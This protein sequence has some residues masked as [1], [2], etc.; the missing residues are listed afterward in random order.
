[1]TESEPSHSPTLPASMHDTVLPD[2]EGTQPSAVRRGPT[3]IG[4][5]YALTEQ[6]GSG[7]MGVVWEAED[8]ELGRKVAVKIL[9]PSTA[10]ADAA[11][12]LR[13]EA[14]LLAEVQHP[15][16]VAVYD[17]GVVDPDRPFVVMERL[18]GRSLS[19]WIGESGPLGWPQATA[20]ALQIC[21]GLGR[22]HELG[23]IHRDLKSSNVFVVLDPHGR[24]IA[25]LIDFG[26]AKA[27]TVTDRARVPTK[28]GIVF[29]TPA[30]MPPEQ[31]RGES[32]DFRAD[33]YAL[34]VILY[35]ML[36]GRRPWVYPTIVETLYAQLYE[37]VPPLRQHAPDVPPELE[38][39]DARCLAKDRDGRYADVHALRG[40]LMGIGKRGGTALPVVLT[41]PSQPVVIRDIARRRSIAPWIGMGGVLA[42]LGFATIW[43]W[44]Q[45]PAQRSDPPPAPTTPAEVAREP[46][47]PP[48]VAAPPPA[49]PPPQVIVVPQPLPTPALSPELVEAKRPST[50]PKPKPK[51]EPPIAPPPAETKAEETKKTEPKSPSLGKAGTFDP[52]KQ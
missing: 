11:M 7:G 34:G 41:P 30:Y 13:R 2:P 43:W 40:E 48:V 49:D 1:L 31:V 36:A 19:A 39:I 20:L 44:K 51:P 47:A 8:R 9:H 28:S 21:E 10:D 27:T 26:L 12:R 45:P 4:G 46:A 23:I 22:A 37:A 18:R 32:L 42:A 17:V 3:V 52:F 16:V 5:R 25:K 38:Q 14:E 33:V 15:N 24:P 29:G 50:K 6:I 35:E